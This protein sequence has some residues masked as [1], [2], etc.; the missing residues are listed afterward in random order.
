MQEMIKK[1]DQWVTFDGR[2]VE[3]LVGFIQEDRRAEGEEQSS[4]VA[5]GAKACRHQCLGWA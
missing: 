2:R 3:K 1:A 4:D 5:D